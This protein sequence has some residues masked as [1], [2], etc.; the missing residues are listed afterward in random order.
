MVE[1]TDFELQ[2]R[3]AAGQP[4]IDEVMTRQRY[5]PRLRALR[6]IIETLVIVAAIS[7]TNMALGIVT[8]LSVAV[9]L[10]I[11]VDG[12]TR[13]DNVYRS[14]Y[15]LYHPYEQRI[16]QFVSS[17]HWLQWFQPY[18]APN[19]TTTVSSKSELI[20]MVQRSRGVLSHDETMRFHASLSLDEH[21][22]ADIMTPVSVVETAD[23][24]DTL[25]PL[26]L[27]SLHKT[28]HSRFPVV[29]GDVHHVVGILYLHDLIDVSRGKKTVRDAMD[30][31]VHYIH[32]AQ[33]LPH[34]LHG[35]L[36]SHHHLFVVV[37]DYRETVGVVTL[38]D[39]I[40]EL[41][42]QPIVDEFDQYDDL[43]AVAQSNP[44]K[45]NM[46]KRRTDI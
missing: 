26:V 31:R 19:V 39:V 8:G 16:I 11:I 43:R 1:V 44:R 9:V 5:L 13:H 45:N 28:G 32:E 38:E 46:P 41:L 36:Q 18:S 4:G 33:T 17:Q 29:D 21:A 3:R 20:A 2:R 7:M 10:L 22:V 23:V 34:V 12:V 35:F 24:N 42:G 6:Q 25:G 15:R 14:A 30:V 40:E 37:N 27:D